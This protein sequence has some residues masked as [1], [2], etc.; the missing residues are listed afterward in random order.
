MTVG[1]KAALQANLPLDKFWAVCDPEDSLSNAIVHYALNEVVLHKILAVSD[2]GFQNC[3]LA[4]QERLRQ[5]FSINP[6]NEKQY[7][8][9]DDAIKE[10]Q[11]AVKKYGYMSKAVTQAV[12]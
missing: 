1:A 4:W 8:Q 3:Q 9:L 2:E 12:F 11:V 7:K 5:W 10:R 6:A